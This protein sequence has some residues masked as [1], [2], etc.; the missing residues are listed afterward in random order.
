MRFRERPPGKRWN[1]YLSGI[2]LS[3]CS[4]FLQST[5]PGVTSGEF[6]FV[7]RVVDGDTLLLVTGERVRLIGVNTPETV[8]AAT[9]RTATRGH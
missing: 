6:E 7:Q 8:G 4:R 5:R 2:S 9:G 3:R 1:W